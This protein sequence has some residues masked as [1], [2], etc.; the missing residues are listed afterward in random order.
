LIHWSAWRLERRWRRQRRRDIRRHRKD[1]AGFERRLATRWR[2]G[3]DGLDLLWLHAH[4]EGAHHNE[5][6]RPAAAADQDY[7]FDA[8][9]KLHARSCRVASEVSALLR[10]GH[11]DG[12]HSRWRSLHELVVTMY[13]I[14]ANDRDVA[15]RYLLHEAARAHSAGVLYQEH[16]SELGYEPVDDQELAAL[17]GV[18]GELERRF[19]TGY[20]RPYGWAAATLGVPRPSFADV[21]KAVSMERWRPWFRMASEAR[22][23]GPAGSRLR[24]A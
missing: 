13:F 17:E 20:A 2:A 7:K 21:E 12:A 1:V 6:A 22:M 11:A 16:S 24:S 8:L 9:S 14:A 10:T 15:E 4:Q 23:R 3:L 19:G 18:R 5:L